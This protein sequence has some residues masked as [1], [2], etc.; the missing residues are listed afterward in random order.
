M[1]HSSSALLFPFLLPNGDH[2]ETS[3]VFS[4]LHLLLMP[5][6]PSILASLNSDVLLIIRSFLLVDAPPT[7]HLPSVLRTCSTLHELGLPF[8]YTVVDLTGYR[9]SDHVITHWKTLFGEGAVL[10]K[11]GRNGG[12]L[13]SIVRVLRLGGQRRQDVERDRVQ[14]TSRGELGISPHL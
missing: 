6:P 2:R 1:N 9:T 5:S 3:L 12:E 4:H 13:G 8:L 11:G 14:F 10:A 7:P